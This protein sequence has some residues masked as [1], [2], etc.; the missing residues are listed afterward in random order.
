M[1]LKYVQGIEK[2]KQLNENQSQL[3][4]IQH[5]SQIIHDLIYSSPLLPYCYGHNLLSYSMESCC[6]S[7]H[8]QLHLMLGAS[9]V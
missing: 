6:K 7:D 5:F 1:P 4:G 9:L 8:C 2:C 3:I